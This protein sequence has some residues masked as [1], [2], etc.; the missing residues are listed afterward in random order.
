MSIEA[1]AALSAA[2]TDPAAVI[3][4]VA[5]SAA[6][7]FRTMLS[8]LEQLNEQMRANEGVMQQ[9]AL[10]ETDNLHQAM[11]GLEKTRLTFELMLQVRN[12]ALEAYQELM[13]M[14]V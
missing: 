13:R 9:L 4:G 2:A 5:A 8:G 11:I 12:K 10:G 7:E 6:P 3:P 1:I 14:Q